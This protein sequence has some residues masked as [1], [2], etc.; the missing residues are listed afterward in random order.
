MKN[1]FLGIEKYI[2]NFYLFLSIFFKG[3]NLQFF[4]NILS[5]LLYHMSLNIWSVTLLLS[6]C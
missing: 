2:Y 4:F 6:K 5:I 1:K 3:I